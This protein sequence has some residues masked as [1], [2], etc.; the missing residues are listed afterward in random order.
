[1]STG[2][3][4]KRRVEKARDKTSPVSSGTV[5][6]DEYKEWLQKK[7]RRKMAASSRKVNRKK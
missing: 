3:T 1:M 2:S 6:L 4:Q 7:S 5:K